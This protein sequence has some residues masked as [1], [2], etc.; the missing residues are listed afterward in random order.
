MKEKIDDLVRPLLSPQSNFGVLVGVVHADSNSVFR[1]GR[2]SAKD[3]QLPGGDTLF[4][5]GSLT[6]VFTAVLLSSMVDDGLVRLDEPVRDLLPELPHWH[7][8]PIRG[9]FKHQHVIHLPSWA[10]P[11]VMTKDLAWGLNTATIPIL[12][13]LDY[14]VSRSDALG[15]DGPPAISDP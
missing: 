4:E 3:P 11:C 6:K 7:A 1:Y 9:R 8:L 2:I 5:I 14:P 13:A 15:P 12:H 10:L